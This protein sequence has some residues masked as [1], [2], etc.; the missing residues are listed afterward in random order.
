LTTEGTDLHKKN[1]TNFINGMKH[2]FNNELK[3][4]GKDRVQGFPDHHEKLSLQVA[5]KPYHFLVL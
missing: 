1:S 4:T 2:S 5:E 3:M